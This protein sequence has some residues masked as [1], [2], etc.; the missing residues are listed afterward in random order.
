MKTNILSQLPALDRTVYP[1]KTAGT[2][3]VYARRWVLS[4]SSPKG[5]IIPDFNE[6]PP[7]QKETL[8]RVLAVRAT[9]YEEGSVKTD[10][11]VLR[12]FLKHFS[13]SD[14]F[15]ESGI[16]V[17]NLLTW[18]ASSTNDEYKRNLRRLVLD[19][20]ELGY[21]AAFE[22]GV[23]TLCDQYQTN[24]L[25]LHPDRFEASRSFTESER[26]QL[27]YQMA[28]ESH[29]GRIPDSVRVPATL[30]LTTGKRPIQTT[31]SKFKDFS[32]EEISLAEGDQRRI[33]VY[34]VPV[35]KQK[36]QRFRTKFNPMPII[37]SFEIW[38]DLEAMRMAHT[39]RLNQLLDAQLTEEQS[40]LLPIYLPVD[41]EDIVQRFR[42][43]EN[44]GLNL[45]DFLFSDRLHPSATWVSATIIKL[46]DYLTIVS[47][48]TGRPLKINA[49]RFRHTRATNLALS[50]ASIDEIADALDHSVRESAKIYVDNLPAR[51]V[52]IG[53]QV[54]ETLGPIA[55]IF[56]G[57]H[58][59]NSDQFI[60]LYT[61]NGTHNVGICGM[62]SFCSENYPIACYECELFN[63][64]P[65]GNHAA[66]QEYVEAQLQE[67]KEIGDS[68]LIENWHTILLAVLERRYIADQHRLQM[69]HEAPEVLS[70][71]YKEASD[72]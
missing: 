60:K 5:L 21:E 19:A 49:K 25:R 22:E 36:G 1:S 34:N 54:E 62:E 48:F 38:G 61:K 29:L 18:F 4:Y 16:D 35:A 33:V 10:V 43:A 51:A 71:D 13:H 23:A 37:S 45:T 3:D 58:V 2:F 56:S 12:A 9:K 40:L 65:F 31:H 17:E 50:G 11:S 41:D 30:I 24:R 39:Q 67:A 52:K 27:Y 70:L 64:N 63:P 42:E 8:L 28:R 44:S 15:F 72:E 20:F 6:W 7:E 68:R 55:K 14:D 59:E 53:S 26:K 69:L 57:I 66:V 47:E 46:N 32:V